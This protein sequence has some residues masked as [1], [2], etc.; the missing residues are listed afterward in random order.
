MTTMPEPT[1]RATF[2]AIQFEIHNSIWLSSN[3]R[4]PHWAVENTRKKAIRNFGYTSG[5]T[6][7]LTFTV[8]VRVIAHIGYATNAKADPGNAAPTLKALIDGMVLAGVL[9]DDSHEHV[10]GPDYRRDTKLAPRGYHTV[11]LELIEEQG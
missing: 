8:P 10:I 6:S 4:H 1:T 2:A 11:R 5:K 3:Q 9:E 7:G